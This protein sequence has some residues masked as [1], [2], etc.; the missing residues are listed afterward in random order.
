ML[1]FCG[2]N[3]AEHFQ[4]WLDIGAKLAAGG[5][6]QPRIYCAN[7]FRKGADGKF[8]WPGY[9]ENMR[10]LEWMV[11]RIEGTAGGSD[12]VFGFSPRYEDL[13]WDGLAFSREQFASVM[14]ID[15]AAWQHELKLHAELFTQLAHGLPAELPA[16]M[17]RIGERLAG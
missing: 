6:A 11:G 5:S 15:R 4:H 3:M 16:T 14:T 17:N 13:R 2:Y 12:N 7:W 10:V 8:V 1:P 9:G